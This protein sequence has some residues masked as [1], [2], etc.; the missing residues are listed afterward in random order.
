MTSNSSLQKTIKTLVECSTNLR[1]TTRSLDREITNPHDKT[2]NCPNTTVNVLDRLTSLDGLV[3][4]LQ[5][6]PRW[7]AM[8]LARI[9][10]CGLPTWHSGKNEIALLTLPYTWAWSTMGCRWDADESKHERPV[11]HHYF[12]P[13]VSMALSP[14]LKPMME[15]IAE[16]G[17]QM[18][19]QLVCS[20]R[21]LGLRSYMT[22]FLRG[23]VG[24]TAKADGLGV[25]IR[26]PI[27]PSHFRTH[28]HSADHAIR[29][30]SP[31]WDGNASA[32]IARSVAED[33]TRAAKRLFSMDTGEASE[34][35]PIVRL[36]PSSQA[37][38]RNSQEAQLNFGVHEKGVLVAFDR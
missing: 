30:N 37:T 16:V 23:G 10:V 34:A 25:H 29:G 2:S 13:K 32:E 1:Q 5:T 12:K 35:V 8:F 36:V 21:W 7:P 22:L 38:A 6:K 17:G 4:L 26:S 19:S 11:R 9:P 33:G 15:G 14:R 31:G 28:A 24:G 3:S 27:C 18:Q 20:R